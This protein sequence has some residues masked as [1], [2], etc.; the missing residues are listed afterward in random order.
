MITFIDVN[1][2]CFEVG[3]TNNH[4]TKGSICTFS[5]HMKDAQDNNSVSLTLI[6]NVRVQ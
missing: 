6:V 1:F 2:Q 4:V 5:Q 3:I